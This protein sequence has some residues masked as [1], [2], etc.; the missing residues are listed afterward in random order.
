LAYSSNSSFVSITTSH[1]FAP[2]FFHPSVSKPLI[3]PYGGSVTIKSMLLSGIRFIPFKQSSLYILFNSI[4]HSPPNFTY[5]VTYLY[6]Y[7]FVHLLYLHILF[8]FLYQYNSY[9]Y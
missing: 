7:L 1:S 4:N 3:V 2:S 6:D 5:L 9:S 8:L